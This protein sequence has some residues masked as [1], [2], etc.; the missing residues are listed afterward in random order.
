MKVDRRRKW[1]DWMWRRCCLEC[2]VWM[3][4]ERNNRKL[5][6]HIYF[7]QMRTYPTEERRIR[8]Y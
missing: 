8:H 7:S 6:K 5:L 2:C 1:S 3:G 4:A